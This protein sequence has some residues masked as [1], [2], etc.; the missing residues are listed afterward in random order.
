MWRGKK[1]ADEKAAQQEVSDEQWKRWV[2]NLSQ[3]QLSK[4]QTEVLAKGL[5][6]AVTPV[7]LPKEDFVV[8]TEK[9][10]C[11]L[12]SDEAEELRSGSDGGFMVSQ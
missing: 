6:F 3:S 4:A 12:N 7:A 11:Q 5:N 2:I 8:A 9:A 1:S 10:C